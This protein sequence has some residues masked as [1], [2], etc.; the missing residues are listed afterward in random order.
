MG[1][2]LDPSSAAWSER[3]CGRIEWHKRKPQEFTTKN[4]PREVVIWQLQLG[5]D[6]LRTSPP[7]L[8]TSLGGY[9]NE[10]LPKGEGLYRLEAIPPFTH[11]KMVEAPHRYRRFFLKKRSILLGSKKRTRKFLLE[12]C[13]WV[14]SQLHENHASKPPCTSSAPHLKCRYERV[15]SGS[16]LGRRDSSVCGG[17]EEL[18]QNELKKMCLTIKNNSFFERENVLTTN[19]IDPYTHACKH[20]CLHTFQFR[21]V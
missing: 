18:N 2:G 16:P 6:P 8:T 4:T 5:Q 3:A 10:N 12:S 21:A 17:R 1:A 11:K 9:H 7:S 19:H 14:R 15:V 20:T 13:I